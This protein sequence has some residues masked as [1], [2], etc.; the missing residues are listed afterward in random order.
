MAS[1]RTPKDPTPEMTH[2]DSPALTAAQ[3]D[4][5]ADQIV[6]KLAG[7]PRA[8]APMLTVSEIAETYRVSRAW[9]YENANRLGAVKLGPSQHAP[10]RFDA[11][12]VVAAL[13]PVD[14]ETV[15]PSPTQTR[16]SRRRKPKRLH[17]VY[18]G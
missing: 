8:P 12:R 18:D 2:D 17:P 5:L 15:A 6:V 13:R 14:G 10:I 11:A 16:P 4:Y 1:Y 7:V 3:L 9:V